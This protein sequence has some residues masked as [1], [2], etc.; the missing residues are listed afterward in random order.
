[1]G[2]ER[3]KGVLSLT[4]HKSSA[5]RRKLGHKYPTSGK[6]SWEKKSFKVAHN[7]QPWKWTSG[8]LQLYAGRAPCRRDFPWL[9]RNSMKSLWHLTRV[10]LCMCSNRTQDTADWIMNARRTDLV[11]RERDARST[12]FTSSPGESSRAWDPVWVTACILNGLVRKWSVGKRH[13]IFSENQ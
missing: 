12:K 10:L 4:S 3:S 8:V 5:L 11:P 2:L 1:M 6:A 13:P 7:D 9:H